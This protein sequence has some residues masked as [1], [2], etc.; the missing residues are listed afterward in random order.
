MSQEA[1]SASSKYWDDK[2]ITLTDNTK[3]NIMK[4]AFTLDAETA[5]AQYRLEGQDAVK[6]LEQNGITEEQL[7]ANPNSYSYVGF[8]AIKDLEDN[9]SKESRVHAIQG[10]TTLGYTNLFDSTSKNF[11]TPPDE[12]VEEKPKPPVEPQEETPRYYA[13][14]QPVQQYQ[15]TQQF[16]SEPEPE[17]EQSSQGFSLSGASKF[18]PRARSPVQQERVVQSQARVRVDSLSPRSKTESYQRP[19]KQQARAPPQR[20]TVAPVQRPLLN[21]DAAMKFSGRLNPV[22]GN[23]QRLSPKPRFGLGVRR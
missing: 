20:A 22:S 13:R 8:T 18:I 16:V 11:I 21:K 19:V 2:K 9:A 5:F 10:L 23:V 17:P 7:V 6:A 3:K 1:I 14:R 12:P 15:P 4:K